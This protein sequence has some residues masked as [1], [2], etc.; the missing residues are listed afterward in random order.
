MLC[1]PLVIPSCTDSPVCA[2]V[3]QQ[4]CLLRAL[5]IQAHTQ[6][7]STRTLLSDNC[8]YVMGFFL[9]I[10]SLQM[11]FTVFYSWL[12]YARIP[13]GHF[14]CCSV[15]WWEHQETITFF[16]CHATG[17]AAGWWSPDGA[18]A[19][20]RHSGFIA[21]V[22]GVWLWAGSGGLSALCW[23]SHKSQF[24]LSCP[25]RTPHCPMAPDRLCNGFWCNSK[26]GL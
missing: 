25:A 22:F 21:E 3:E 10:V 6:L 17:S 23:D 15:A 16:F 11:H 24:L 13:C 19:V 20:Q 1:V 7:P 18:D 8:L 14:S 2:W 26:I 4:R 12:H 9:L 5:Y